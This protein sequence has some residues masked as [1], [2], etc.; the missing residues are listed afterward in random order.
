MPIYSQ[1]PKFKRA[2]PHPLPADTHIQYQVFCSHVV[3]IT[4]LNVLVILNNKWS[5]VSS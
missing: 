4:V 5:L 3:N 2:K 1:I